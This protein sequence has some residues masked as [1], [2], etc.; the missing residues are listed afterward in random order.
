MSLLDVN[1]L[2]VRFGGI[3]AL[4]NLT[5]HVDEGEIC[6]LIGPNGAGKTTLFNCLSRIYDPTSGQLAFAGEDLLSH[7]QHEI[8]A[9]GLGRTFQNLGLF[10][11]MTVLENVMVGAHTRMRAGFLSQPTRLPSV[12]REERQVRERSLELLE[13]L[14]LTDVADERADGLPFGTLKRIEVARALATQPRLLLL[15]EPASGLTH[16]EVDELAALIRRLRDD[17]GLTILLVEHHMGMVM[18]I[19]DR[20]VV[21]DFGKKIADGR[22]DE[23]QAD[24]AVIEAY[25]GAPA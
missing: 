25:L 2:G 15:D 21:L 22:P 18:Q 5:F 19:C 20:V 3:V 7:R 4:D 1:G 24:P 8:A 14:D 10:S 12:R 6:G 17:E 23:V 16:G 9:L 11:S 13:L